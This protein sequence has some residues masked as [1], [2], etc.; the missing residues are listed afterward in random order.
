M[1]TTAATRWAQI[2]AD[3]AENRRVLGELQGHLA[4]CRALVAKILLRREA[5][6]LRAKP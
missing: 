2:Q 1:K 6:K 3:Q 4:E 5:R